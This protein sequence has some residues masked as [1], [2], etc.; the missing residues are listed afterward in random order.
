MARLARVVVPGMPHHVTQRGNRRQ[1]TFFGGEDYA[2]D[3]VI[4]PDSDDTFNTGTSTLSDG[5]DTTYDRVEY[6]YNRQ[7]EAIQ[8]KDQ[9]ETT[10]GYAQDN[11][12]TS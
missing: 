10:H 8:I 7:G 11:Q 1:P 4:Y 5:V 2:A 12:G 9:A 3:A 6:K